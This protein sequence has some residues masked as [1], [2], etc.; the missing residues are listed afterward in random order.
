MFFITALPIIR[1]KGSVVHLIYL[2]YSCIF[3]RTR[4]DKERGLMMSKIG[5]LESLC[6]AMQ[7]ERTAR[8][9]LESEKIGKH[10]M[11]G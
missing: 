2:V 9:M 10:S 8:K 11:A 1:K 7:A 6:R 5:K 4:Y 3:Q